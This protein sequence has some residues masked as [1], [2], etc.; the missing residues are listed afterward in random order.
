MPRIV[1]APRVEVERSPALALTFRPGEGGIRGR[2][3]ALVVGEGVSGTVLAKVERRLVAEG[4]KPLRIGVRLG[5]DL[6][7]FGSADSSSPDARLLIPPS[8]R[9]DSSLSAAFS[10]SRIEL[11][12]LAACWF[13]NVWAHATRVP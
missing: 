6:A 13:P 7:D 3:I 12:I 4:A 11:R 8:A 9:P 2:K 10:W 5:L 1:A